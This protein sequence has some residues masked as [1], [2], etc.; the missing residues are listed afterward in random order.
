MTTSKEALGA[1]ELLAR[2]E[3]AWS[4]I[5]ARNAAACARG[6][7]LEKAVRAAADR[8]SASAAGFQHLQ[9]ELK[10]VPG[11]STQIREVTTH[12]AALGEHLEAL[13]ERLTQLAIAQVR[14]SEAQWRREQLERADVV[15][16][17]RKQELQE[18]RERMALQATRR[19]EKEQEERQQVFQE[20]FEA[21]R[22][23]VAQHGAIDDLRRQQGPALPTVSLADMQPDAGSDALD[24]FYG[25]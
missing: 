25:T 14:S 21:D 17:Q 11:C 23:F 4:S 12:V 2:Y 1:K 19:V 5:A 13:D 24:D 3:T 16:A 6:A 22:A 7:E 8:C 20:Q 15:Q 9:A 18:L 10:L